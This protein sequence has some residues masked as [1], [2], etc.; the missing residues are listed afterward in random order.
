MGRISLSSGDWAVVALYVVVTLG[1]ALRVRAGQ[2]TAADYF[3]AGRNMPWIVVAIS[4]YATLMST[5]SFVAMPGEAYK[6]GMLLS[7]NSVGYAIFTPLAMWLFLRFFYQTKSFT[8]YEYLGRRFNGTT[9]TLGAV[10]FLIAR[11]IYAGTVFYA[12]AKVFETLVGWDPTFTVLVLGVF[13][14]GYTAIGGMRAVMFTD[15]VQTVILLSGLVLV[16]F[17]IASLAGFDFVEVWRYAKQHDHG[18]GRLT[19]AS[20]YSFDPHVRYTIWVWLVASIMGPP[21]NYGA[22]Q[23]VVQRL[24]SSKSYADAKRAIWLKTLAALPISLAFYFVGIMLFYYYG[25]VADLPGPVEADQVLGLFINQNLPTPVPGLIAAALMAAL[26]S[27]VDSTVGS[28]ST[29]TCV[30]L[31]KRAGMYPTDEAKQVRL[32]KLLT[33]AWGVFVIGLALLLTRAS[34]GV[35]GTVLE[36]AAVWASLWGVLLMVMLAGVTTRW[37]SPR[38]AT[39]A[40][41]VGMAVNLT[42]P[43]MLYYGVPAEDRISFA[44]VGM[45]G[46]ILTAAIVFLG[47]L[48]DPS[49][50]RE[51]KGLVLADVA[52]GEEAAK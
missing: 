14:V 6:N 25:E 27:T 11:S 41:A 33:V 49:R 23:L 50:P 5:I 22:D 19:E 13:A 17:K 9:H 1:I 51:T 31:L 8:C 40:L 43:W 12:A 21:V 39:V 16:F 47:S 52:Y 34:Q 44:W 38:A 2:K 36:V 46:V 18:F 45:P 28:L 42:L 32:G 15:V 10:I 20:F 24:L 37:A 30:D 29:V 35:E 3:L 48:V 7:L 26:M 4:M